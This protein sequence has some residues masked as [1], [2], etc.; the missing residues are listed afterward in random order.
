MRKKRDLPVFIEVLTYS[1]HTYRRGECF[2]AAP[3]KPVSVLADEKE[4]KFTRRER[5]GFKQPERKAMA[6]I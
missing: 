1:F 4:G 3:R 2:T 6:V 5:G